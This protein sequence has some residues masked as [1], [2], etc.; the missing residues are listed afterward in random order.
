MFGPELMEAFRE[1]KAIWD[2][3]GKM[4]PGKIVDAVSHRRRTCG[5]GPTTRRPQLE[6]Q[7]HFPDDGGSFAHATTAL[8]G[9][10][11]VPAQERRGRRETT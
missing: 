3:N 11:Q 2:P 8:R 10:R 4:N 9:R 1:F 7:F 6:T 5:S